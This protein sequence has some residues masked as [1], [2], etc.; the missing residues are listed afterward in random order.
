VVAEVIFEAATD[1]KNQLRYTAGED[2]KMLI[3]N[4]QQY[5]DATFFGGIK[6]QFGL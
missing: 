4:R 5:D 2:A 3:A 1:G 6:A